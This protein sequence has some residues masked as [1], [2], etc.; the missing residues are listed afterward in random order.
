MSISK[1]TAKQHL[2][3]HLHGRV[4]HTSYILSTSEK[5]NILSE[6]LSPSLRTALFTTST[7]LDNSA[8]ASSSAPSSSPWYS[9]PRRTWLSS[10]MIYHKRSSVTRSRMSEGPKTVAKRRSRSLTVWKEGEN[11]KQTTDGEIRSRRSRSASPVVGRKE[12]KS[13][14]KKRDMRSEYANANP[15]RKSTSKIHPQSSPLPTESPNVLPAN[16]PQIQP[17]FPLPARLPAHIEQQLYLL[18]YTKLLSPRRPAHSRTTIQNLMLYIQSVHPGVETLSH[19]PPSPTLPAHSTQAPWS[20]NTPTKR[21]SFSARKSNRRRL[22]K[23]AA[24]TTVGPGPSPLRYSF[25]PD[26]AYTHHIQSLT[27]AAAVAATQAVYHKKQHDIAIEVPVTAMVP[28]KHKKDTPTKRFLGLLKKF[29]KVDSER[30][31]RRESAF[32]AGAG[33]FPARSCVSC[34]ND[35]VVE[36][37]FGKGPKGGVHVLIA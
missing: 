11:G 28:V 14:P 17:C 30:A 2:A 4:S 35:G 24:G 34:D 10:D 32:Y 25:S 15:K 26:S 21:P 8:S 19:L 23:L 13:V 1:M 9:P 7:K 29:L 27:R 5:P 31:R 20:I 36:I 33:K 12:W 16:L 18:S 22:A 6:I 37:D 3:F